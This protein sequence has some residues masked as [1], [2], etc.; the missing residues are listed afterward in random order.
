MGADTE[1]SSLLFTTH[2]D[3]QA[4]VGQEMQSNC[5]VWQLAVISILCYFD[6]DF[7]KLSL[8]ENLPREAGGWDRPMFP[9]CADEPS[10]SRSPQTMAIRLHLGLFSDL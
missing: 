6:F 1:P 3:S 7:L 2:H 4:P 9:V 8:K 10:S 5:R